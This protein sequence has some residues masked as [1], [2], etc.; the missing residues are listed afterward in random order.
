MIKNKQL[1]TLQLYN[2]LR[3]GSLLLISVFLAKGNASMEHIAGFETSMLLSASFSFFTI[4]ALSHCLYPVMAG[5]VKNERPVY[6]FHVFMLYVLAGLLACICILMASF[7]LDDAYFE[8][9][10][11][12][13]PAIYILFNSGTYLTDN[14]FVIEK[15]LTSAIVWGG[16]SFLIQIVLICFPLIYLHNL[17]LAL[18]LLAAFAAIRFCFTMILVWPSPTVTLF[19]PGILKSMLNISWPVMLSLMLGSG[20]VYVNQFLVKDRFSASDFALFRY[21]TREFPLFAILTNSFSS[22]FSATYATQSQNSESTGFRRLNHQVFIPALILMWLS[23]PL[24]KLLFNPA[25]AESWMLFN[26]LLLMVPSKLVFPQ[27]VLLALG[28][29]K[30]L[31]YAS[32]IEILAGIVLTL[33]LLPLYGLAGAAMALMLAHWVEKI[34]LMFF[35]AIHPVPTKDYLDMPSLL[36][37]LVLL[38]GSFFMNL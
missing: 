37:Y 24:F 19:Q 18:F 22:I 17:E 4:A 9:R 13:Y 16:A 34:V 25:L 26:I 27:S 1:F 7:Y 5:A 23:E 2:F 35:C 21:G 28:K 38:L 11:F 3:Q 6:Y 31:L 29:S 30:Y 33:W 32:I 14:Y 15:K 12:W 10:L 36:I 20:F 8:S